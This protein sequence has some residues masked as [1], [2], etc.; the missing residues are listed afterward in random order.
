MQVISM[1][2][3]IVGSLLSLMLVVTLTSTLS[4]FSPK[5]IPLKMIG[6]IYDHADE[7]AQ[8]QVVQRMSSNCREISSMD[9]KT[10]DEQTYRFK[11]LCDD[12]KKVDELKGVCPKLIDVKGAIP[13]D[14]YRQTEEACAIVMSGD[15]EKQCEQIDT[16]QSLDYSS[17]RQKC[18]EYSKGNLD[19]RELLIGSAESFMSGNPKMNLIDI[20]DRM[21]KLAIFF[22]FFL[23]LIFLALHHS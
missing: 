8:A 3:L 2:R 23:L 9:Q 13:E 10:L 15:L 21:Q 17:I 14:Q 16:M 12:K 20:I 6:Q 18:S 5:D 1:F 11:E 4:D 22:A 7:D 19:G